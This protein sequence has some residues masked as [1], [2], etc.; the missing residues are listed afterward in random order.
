M[1]RFALLLLAVFCVGFVLPACG[2]EDESDP[3]GLGSSPYTV[4]TF[5]G[6]GSA[7]S[8]NGSAASAT[9]NTPR[10]AVVDSSGNVF[11]ADSGNHLIRKI[12]AA[13]VVS[14]YAGAGTAG[15]AD[16]TGALASFNA[17]FALA[18]DSSGTLYVADKDNNKIRKISAGGV[19]TTLAGSGV[20]GYTNANGINAKFSGP[21]GIAVD[22]SG[23][24]YV[25][26]SSHR[27][28]KI[29]PGGDVTTL[30]GAGSAGSING[31]GTAVYFNWPQGL[32]VDASGNVYVS[33]TDN[34]AIRKITAAG[35]VTTLAG[36]G[37]L[38]GSTDATGTSARFYW[39]VGMMLDG[40][41]NLLVADVGN[42]KIRKITPAGVVTT[43]AGTGTRSCVNG[44]ASVA[45]FNEPRAICMYSA[46]HFYVADAANN[47]IREI[48]R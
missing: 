39:P 9:F 3:P 27:I 20:G 30:A 32:A 8:A 38:S 34:H 26:E 33:D 14:T 10:C 24:V 12:T 37:G 43:F 18:V 46:N 17:P 36:L 7:G 35:V 5:A 23:Y 40:S 4:G 29:S 45:T 48:F 22:S 25:A 11:V 6:T 41:G 1:T 15:A 13:G 42:H 2:D 16:G 44:L 19:V 47:R 21:I 28:R 31:T